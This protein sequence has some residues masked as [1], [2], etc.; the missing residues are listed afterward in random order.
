MR[1]AANVIPRFV[2]TEQLPARPGAESAAKSVSLKV[3][4][5]VR[6]AV[7]T[8]GGISLAIYINGLM[9]G[10][11]KLWLQEGDLSKLLN[12]SESVADLS[13]YGFAVEEPQR[14]LLNSQRM[15]RKLLDALEQMAEGNRLFEWLNQLVKPNQKPLKSF[16]QLARQAVKDHREN[17]LFN[18]ARTDTESAVAS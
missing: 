6:F 17:L 15:Y 3:E 5:E 9:D 14:S 13:Q 1:E 18:I 16:S 8:Y 4:R 2:S 11:K 7:V 10:L 12:D